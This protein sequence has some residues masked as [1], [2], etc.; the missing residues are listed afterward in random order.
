MVQC[1]SE[2]AGCAIP[3]PPTRGNS[4]GVEGTLR[5]VSVVLLRRSISEPCEVSQVLRLRSPKHLGGLTKIIADPWQLLL[6][7]ALTAGWW[8]PKPRFAQLITKRKS[9]TLDVLGQCGISWALVSSEAN[10]RLVHR[11]PTRCNG[12]I[13]NNRAVCGDRRQQ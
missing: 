6:Q 1:V 9:F 5:P 13:R 12:G 4:D 2:I 11:Q 3:R 7:K 10:L 8:N